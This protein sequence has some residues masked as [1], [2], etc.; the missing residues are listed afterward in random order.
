MAPTG[1]IHWTLGI[2][3]TSSTV[4]IIFVKAF[5]LLEILFGRVRNN[6]ATLSLGLNTPLFK[7][8]WLEILVVKVR[9]SGVETFV[10]YHL[11][12]QMKEELRWR[13]HVWKLECSE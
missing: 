6:A 13:R 9:K 8:L 3:N 12:P 11:N 5:A 4:M 2:A 10:G 7:T 1:G